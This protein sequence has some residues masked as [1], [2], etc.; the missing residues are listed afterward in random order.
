[1]AMPVPHTDVAMEQALQ[2]MR[3]TQRHA[4]L[5][6]AQAGAMQRQQRGLQ[7]PMQW[8]QN[9]LKHLQDMERWVS[10]TQGLPAPG[11]VERCFPQKPQYSA[12]T[13]S[14]ILEF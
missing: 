11:W 12:L 7:H 10:S 4:L 8:L 1:M 5:L 9:Q 3:D 2:S 14:C 13:P 6:R